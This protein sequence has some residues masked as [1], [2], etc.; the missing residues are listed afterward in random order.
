MNRKHATSTPPTTNTQ[1]R[2]RQASKSPSSAPVAINSVV[3]QR[4]VGNQATQDLVRRGLPISGRPPPGLPLLPGVPHNADTSYKT[5]AQRSQL[6]HRVTKIERHSGIHVARQTWRQKYERYRQQ[7]IKQGKPANSWWNWLLE[8]TGMNRYGQGAMRKHHPIPQTF[9]RFDKHPKV[10]TR[11]AQQKINVHD[12]IIEIPEGLHNRIHDTSMRNWNGELDAWFKA[13]PKFTQAQLYEKVNAM[14]ADPHYNIPKSMRTRAPNY[15]SGK[16]DRKFFQDR[17]NRKDQRKQRYRVDPS[18][19]PKPPSLKGAAMRVGGAAAVS[20]GSSMFYGYMKKRM[21]DMPMPKIDKRGAKDY[22]S[23]PNT[24][25]GMRFLDLLF[26][27][28]VTF[29]KELLEEHMA[30]KA[31]IAALIGLVE[32]RSLDEDPSLDEWRAFQRRTEGVMEVID[33]YNR[34]LETIS[35]NLVGALEFE[36]LA[37][38]KIQA[39]QRLL[40]IFENTGGLLF[41]FYGVGMPLEDVTELYGLLHSSIAR[42]QQTFANLRQLASVVDRLKSDLETMDEELDYIYKANAYYFVNKYEAPSPE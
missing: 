32:E 3:L 24:I 42:H 38:K 16:R 15:T 37:E 40:A 33:S 34:R 5:T 12:W 14:M 22:F 27:Q 20:F 1:R 26:K 2:D 21:S 10:A 39:A 8:R 25:E 6:I 23:D 28:T 13:N 19:A 7:K 4:Y 36:P 30:K 11:L 35:K 41:L 9:A 17:K 31:G 18:G 29:Q